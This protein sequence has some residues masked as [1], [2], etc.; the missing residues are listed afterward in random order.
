VESIKTRRVL[1]GT[2]QL[3]VPESIEPLKFPS[4]FNPEG[5][6][7]RDVSI[8]CYKSFASSF[9]D[10][11]RKSADDLIFGDCLSG[12]GARGIRVANEALEFRR[13]FLND[14]SPVSIELAKLSARENKVEEKCVFSNREAGAFLSARLEN[15]G[16]RFDALDL[17]PFGTPS[18][19]VDEALKAT[20]HHGILSVSATDTAVLCGVYP[21]VALRKYL[22]LPLRTDYSQEV[23]I[24]LMLGLLSF[25]AMRCEAG[26]RPLF[27]HHDKHYFRTYSL[28]EIGNNYSRQNEAQ[29]GYILHCF[30][31][32]SRRMVSRSDFFEDLASRLHCTDCDNAAMKIGG[33]LWIGK[34]QSGEFVQKCSQL[35]DLPVFDEE[36]DLPLYYDLSK[37]SDELGTSTPKIASVISK[38]RTIGHSASRTRLNPK[39][40]RTD[41]PLRELRMILVELV[42]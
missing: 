42:R 19:F 6:F 25:T 1:E 20:K 5:R 10:P 14:I 36:L 26:I 9:V 27:A 29:I 17:D 16:E 40:V 22:G 13:V 18:P 37:L 24:R 38:L 23:G 30:K 33:P 11:R 15:A 3:V 34:I 41:A 8:I 31:C 28:V 2:T 4:F 35:S 7:V 32:G 12:T 39:A 21:S